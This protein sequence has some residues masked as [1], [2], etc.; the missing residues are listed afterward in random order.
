MKFNPLF[1]IIIFCVLFITT[2]SFIQKSLDLSSKYF[3]IGLKDN[4]ISEEKKSVLLKAFKAQFGAK[5]NVDRIEFVGTD[6]LWLVF[7]SG[8]EGTNTFAIQTE[9]IKGKVVLNQNAVTNT[10]SGNPCSWCYF[11]SN[12]GCVCNKNSAGKC[13]HT[14]TSLMDF[15]VF[16][17]NLGL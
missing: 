12:N 14:Q 11:D 16:A 6:D 2:T 5:S 4:P 3:E 10:C 1:S 8:G 7:Q 15:R 9:T 13:N 17:S